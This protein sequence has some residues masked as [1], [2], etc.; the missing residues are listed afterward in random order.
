MEQYDVLVVGNDI[1]SL[2]AALF[3]ARKMRKVAVLHDA[4][5]LNVKKDVED[6]TDAENQKYVFKRRPSGAVSGLEK[7]RFYAVIWNNSEWKAKSR[8]SRVPLTPSS[9]L[10]DPSLRG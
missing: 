6:I 4:G 2:S 7:G 8:H 3:L 1:G 10:T 5:A 9:A